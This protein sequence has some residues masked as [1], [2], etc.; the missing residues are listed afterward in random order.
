LKEFRAKYVTASELGVLHKLSSRIIPARLRSVG[1]E[2][3]GGPELDGTIIYIFERS[4]VAEV[5]NI[6][7]TKDEFEK[8]SKSVRSNCRDYAQ[9][10][11]SLKQTMK[12]LNF[13]KHEISELEKRGFLKRVKL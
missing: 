3:V 12:I 4:K 7:L 8:A 9:G 10:F 5:R 11:L 1:V 6:R 13:S 2:P